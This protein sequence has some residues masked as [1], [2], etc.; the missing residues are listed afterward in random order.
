[1]VGP[2]IAPLRPPAHSIWATFLPPRSAACASVSACSTPGSNAA[3]RGGGL[4]KNACPLTWKVLL[5]DPC[6]AG[7]APVVSVNQPAPVFG[8]DWVRR[9]LPDAR[10]PFRSMLRNPGTTPWSAYLRTKFC[11]RPSAAKNRKSS[12]PRSWPWPW[13][14]PDGRAVSALDPRDEPGGEDRGDQCAHHARS[15]SAAVRHRSHDLAH[16]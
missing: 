1:M 13:P 15:V 4:P 8:G 14:P 7:H 16:H 11:V 12:S 2:S 3:V 6:T 9:P 10:A 5:V